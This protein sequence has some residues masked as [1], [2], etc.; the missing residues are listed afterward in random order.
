MLQLVVFLG[1]FLSIY[2]IFFILIE[3]NSRYKLQQR[4]AHLMDEDTNTTVQS[5]ITLWQKKIIQVVQ[6]FLTR[7]NQRRKL[8]EHNDDSLKK[9]L[10][11]A[12]FRF[13][14]AV[15]MFLLIRVLFVLIIG[16]GFVFS[17]Y[18]LYGSDWSWFSSLFFFSVFFVLIY[19]V[20]LVLLKWRVAF[21]QAELARQ[22]PDFFDLICLCLQAGV[23]TDKAIRY[24]IISLYR[25]H[26][27]AAME[28]DLLLAELSFY[29]DRAV[30]WKNAFERN[31]TNIGVAAMFKRLSEN[32]LLGVSMLNALKVQADLLRAQHLD[33]LEKKALK[34][35][36]ILTVYLIGFFLPPL[37][38]TILGGAAISIFHQ[39]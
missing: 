34:M 20:P 36:S 16:V 5:I 39:L 21:F 19:Y 8:K 6:K 38:V 37:F 25:T 10:Q 1:V 14:T 29:S 32:E 33:R 2:I 23:N 18:S 13:Q 28:M 22:L 17:F 31:E 12:G 9:K 30:A 26:P 11:S 4:I 24:C 35:P 3:V 7:V 27:Q 15:E